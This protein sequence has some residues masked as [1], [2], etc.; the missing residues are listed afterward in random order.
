MSAGDRGR[1]AEDDESARERR[2]ELLIQRLPRG[3]QPKVRWLRRPS[4]RLARI[5]AGVLLILGGLLFFLPI[6]GLWM[7]PLGLLLLAEDIKPLRRG[8]AQHPRLDRASSAA[9]VGSRARTASLAHGLACQPGCLG[10]LCHAR[11]PGDRPWH[12]QSGVHR[13]VGRPAS[14]R[15]TGT[16]APARPGVGA[17]DAPCPALV[18][19]VDR[20]PDRAGLLAGHTPRLMARSDPD[21]RWRLPVVQGDARDSSAGRWRR[22]RCNRPAARRPTSPARSWKSWCSTSCSRSIA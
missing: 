2:I 21:R 9:L 16:G 7:L 15:T 3:F 19:R 6:L 10:Q 8:S 22:G 12:R 4:A 14:R 1:E 13:S 5:A 17:W 11:D 18:S 20:P